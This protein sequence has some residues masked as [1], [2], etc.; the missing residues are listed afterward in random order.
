MHRVAL[1]HV[2]PRHA[3]TTYTTVVLFQPCMIGYT[4]YAQTP[5]YTQPPDPPRLHACRTPRTS[6]PAGPPP[7]SYAC[8]T[9]T[10]L[11]WRALRSPVAAD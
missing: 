6:T 5:E 8:L 10:T 11:S 9:M 7:V 1:P 3:L 4:Q 2:Q